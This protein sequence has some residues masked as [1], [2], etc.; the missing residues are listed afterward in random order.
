MY[1]PKQ[2]VPGTVAPFIVGAD[3]PDWMLFTALDNLIAEKKVPVMIAISI[4]N[5]SGDAQGSERG[6]EYDTMSGKYAE[7]VETGGAAA[8]G[9][10]GACEAD[11][12]SGWTGDDGW[13]F[14]RVV[15]ADHGVVSPGALSPGADVLG[16]VCESAV[17]AECRRH[18][19]GR[20][21]FMSI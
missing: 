13:E 9:E 4:G 5:G 21:S 12:G 20:G 3:G 2:Y 10:G 7:L 11:E 19:M 1:V 8:G 16:H 6:L 17:A 15:R 18:R 14:G